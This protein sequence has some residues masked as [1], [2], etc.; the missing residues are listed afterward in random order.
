[1]SEPVS[2]ASRPRGKPRGGLGKYL[3]ARGRGHRGGG[4]PA[5]FK[6]RLLLDGERSI[7]DEDEEVIL[8]R[9]QKFSKRQLGRNDDRYKEEEPALGSDGALVQC[10][11]DNHHA[12]FYVGEP[13]AEP[14]VDLSAFLARQRLQD[15]ATPNS[16]STPPLNEEAL[17]D[18]DASLAHIGTTKSRQLADGND[19]KGK[20][21]TLDW[22]EELEDMKREKNVADAQRS[23]CTVI[24]SLYPLQR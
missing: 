13:I 18:I 20:L 22:D 4:R 19:R 24:S 10:I 16:S 23:M 9:E 17:A 8:E 15:D 1:M 3:R 14:E 11:H 2:P 12:N 5:E 6:E 21:Q 7:D